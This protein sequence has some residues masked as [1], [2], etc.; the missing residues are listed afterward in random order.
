DGPVAGPARDVDLSSPWDVVW[1]RD[2]VVVAM[3]GNHTLGFFDPLGQKVSRFAG[4]TVEGLYDAPAEEAFFAQPS[5]LAADGDRLWLVD[6]ETSALRWI[7]SDL[8]VHTAVG[9]GLFDFGHVDG[10][11]EKALLQH[12]LGVAVLPDGSVA[13]AD[14]YNGAVRRYEPGTKQV[15]T[16]ATGIAEPSG[17]AVVDGK[18]AVVASA[19]VSALVLGSRVHRRRTG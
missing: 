16:L 15:S 13:I 6:S 11:A 18:I 5:G 12:P 2:G 8:T 7:D 17:I 14:T 19:A 10:D 3:A 4:T 9:Q 1:W